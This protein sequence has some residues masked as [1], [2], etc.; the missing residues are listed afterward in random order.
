MQLH[1]TCVSSTGAVVRSG[2]LLGHPV[3]SGV[4][5][6]GDNCREVTVTAERNKHKS[7]I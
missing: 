7:D 5:Q 2:L 1:P 4:V 3:L 6:V